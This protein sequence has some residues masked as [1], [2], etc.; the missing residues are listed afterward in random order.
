MSVEAK[1]MHGLKRKSRV[2]EAIPTASMSDIVFL[3]L[4][5]FMVTTVFRK[6]T[7]LKIAFP[8][9]S[10][11]KK[12]E[13]KTKNILHVWVNKDQGNTIENE[14]GWVYVDDVAYNLADPSKQAALVEKLFQEFAERKGKILIAFRAD[15]DIPYRKVN[16][17]LDMLKQANTV[18]VMFAATLEQ[19]T[20]DLRR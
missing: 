17:A 4:I 13:F 8:E 12:T 2:S 18:Q 3:L 1:K 15:R 20:Y 10:A 5:F 14:E 9:A 19:E 11:L 7:P 16:A 6:E